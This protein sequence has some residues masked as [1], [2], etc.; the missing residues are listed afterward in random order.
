MAS[1]RRAREIIRAS[2][3]L[4]SFRAKFRAGE[5]KSR[6]LSLFLRDDIA[7]QNSKRFL[8]FARNDRKVSVY[9]ELGLGLTM[10]DSF[11]CKA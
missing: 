4:L 5:T 11:D 9:L 6:N 2:R 1:E 3:R 8:D 10:T 7:L